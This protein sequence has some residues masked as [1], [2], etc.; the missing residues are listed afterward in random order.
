MRT[1][2]NA[3]YGMGN[4]LA[5]T[6]LDSEQG[7]Y[8]SAILESS[9]LLLGIINDILDV[10]ALQYGDI[11]IEEGHVP[12][13]ELLASLLSAMEFKKKEKDIRLYL[14]I[15]PD[16]PTHIH[17]D[18]LRINQILYNLMGNA[19]KYTERGQVGLKVS[20][21]DPSQTRC[22]IQFAVCDTGIGIAQEH[23]PQVFDTFKRVESSERLYEGA[24][25][26]LAIVK[27]LVDLLKGQIRVESQLG[28]GSVF[29]V[30]LP[31]GVSN[32]LHE[33]NAA[34]PETEPL[35]QTAWRILVVEDNKMNMVVA[36]KTL[37]R[38]FP[39]IVIDEAEHGGVA[40]Q[41]LQCSSYDL[42]LMDLQMPVVDGYEATKA[43]RTELPPPANTTPVVAMTANAFVAKEQE[44]LFELGFDHYLLKPFHPDDLR[45]VVLRYLRRST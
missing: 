27:N 4:L 11:K 17:G 25:L 10:S 15:A 1:P 24:G 3:I 45:N 30:C 5:G 38:C 36:R 9:K 34:S 40:V 21:A 41:K 6:P 18:G 12:I 44:D 43:I 2:L 42:V 35:P 19:I 37:Q 28:K 39:H 23:L 16:V 20:M 13:R 14:D 8:I 31:V 33:T 26:G 7:S 22:T 29:T 32:E